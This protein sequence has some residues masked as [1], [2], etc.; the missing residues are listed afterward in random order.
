LKS[1]D[2]FAEALCVVRFN[3]VLEIVAAAHSF[4]LR[5]ELVFVHSEYFFL[6]IIRGAAEFVIRRE[7]IF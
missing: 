3:S 7:K 6:K 5:F 4:R 2:V 1:P